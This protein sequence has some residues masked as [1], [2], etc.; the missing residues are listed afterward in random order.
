MAK[1]GKIK[2]FK[3]THPERWASYISCVENY[4]HANQVAEDGLKATT[5]LCM[6]SPTTFDIA[7]N[8][9]APAPLESVTY[10]DLKKKLQDHFKPKLS[11]IAWRHAFEQRE[12]QPVVKGEATVKVSFKEFEGPLNIVVVEGQRTSL[13]GLDWVDA[14]GIRVTGINHTQT[15]DLTAV[16]QEFADI[17]LDWFEA[18]G[19]QVTGLHKLQT[20]TLA[21]VCKE[22]ADVFSSELGSYTGPP[23]SLKLDPTV[24]P[25]RVKPRRVPFALKSKIDAE[26]DKLLQQ[27]ILEPVDSSPWETPIVTPLKENGDI[28]I[29]ADY[30]CTLNKALQQHAYPVPVVSHI[31]ASLKEGKFFAKLDLVQAYQQLP[32]DDAAAEAQ[33]IVTH[34]GAFK[35]KRLQ[36][37]VNVAPGI[38]QSVMENTLRGIPGVC[39]YF[40]DVLIAGDSPQ[41]LAERLAYHKPLLGLFTTSKQTPRILSPRMLRWSI[42]LSAYDYSLV[43]K[44]GKEMGHADALS[45]LPLPTVEPDPTPAVHILSIQ[46]L[47]ESALGSGSVAAETATDHTLKRVLSWVLSGWPDRCPAED[48]QRFWVKRHELS[49]FN[50][51]LLWGSRVVIPASL[52]ARILISLHEG[53]PG[54]VR[55]KALAR[56]HLWWPGIDRAIE[57]QVHGCHAC[58]QSRPEMPQAPV[59]R[60][61]ET[62]TPWSRIHVDYAGPF[63]GQFFL[64]VVDSHSKWLE[65]VP[66]SSTTAAK[67]IQV[68]RNIFAAHG[69][70]DV[71]VSDNGPQFTSTEFQGFLQ[72]NMIRHVAS[73]PF[74]PSTN[75]LAERMVHIAKDALKKLHRL[76]TKLDRLH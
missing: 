31:L 53:H 36:F 35:V 23:V 52:R 62:H 26:L 8:L 9:V 39:P 76:V 58:Q 4:L 28:R 16:C 3:V 38:F 1:V 13:I 34:R 24:Q 17:G 40:D 20:E 69:L 30:K 71:L 65:V 47:P 50:G 51:C 21:D 61:E 56:S 42:F 10:G 29:C 74:H 27:G 49:T 6:C 25:I 57:A 32:A 11:I 68:L 60:W 14:L 44:P 59:H 43:H 33:T 48:F 54:I 7:E 22:F 55:M 72:A 37:G 19:I 2:E 18:L 46:E 73:A 41:M 67:T 64:V 75:S 66:V 63:Q 5:L 12:Q 70:P 15:A 45:R